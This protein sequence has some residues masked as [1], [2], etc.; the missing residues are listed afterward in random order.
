MYRC[1]CSVYKY[2]VRTRCRVQSF[3]EQTH[4]TRITGEDNSTKPKPLWRA[5]P[6]NSIVAVAAAAAALHPLLV[7][8]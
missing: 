1:N 4:H 2:G 5:H 3:E 8:M 7:S 6:L